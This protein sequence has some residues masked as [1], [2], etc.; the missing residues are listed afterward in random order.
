MKRISRHWLFRFSQGLKIYFY[1]S[2]TIRQVFAIHCAIYIDVP[3][4]V[5]IILMGVY[6]V[7]QMRIIRV[8]FDCSKLWYNFI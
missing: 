6:S 2:D 5:A 1:L 7:V 3:S 4:C 8:M